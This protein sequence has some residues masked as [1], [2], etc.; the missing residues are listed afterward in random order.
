MT[1]AHEYTEEINMTEIPVRVTNLHETP[2]RPARH[3]RRSVTTK[4]FVLTS[5]DQVQQILN[6]DPTR[7][8]AYVQV[9]GADV[10]LCADIGQ[11]QDPANVATGLPNPVGSLVSHSTPMWLP[12]ETQD[13]VWAASPAASDALVSLVIFNDAEG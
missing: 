11:A 10:V 12:L 8:C 4:T 5:D 7:A 3:R 13:P 1:Q 9:T 6:Q 2:A